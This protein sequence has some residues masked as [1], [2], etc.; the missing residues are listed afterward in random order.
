MISPLKIVGG[1]HAGDTA[2]GE[3]FAR[4]LIARLQALDW[5]L[6]H[7]QN[8]LKGNAEPGREESTTT[9][10][11]TPA[12]PTGIAAGIFGPST[13]AGISAQLFEPTAL[14]VKVAGV[15]VGGV[16]PWLQRWVVSDR[17]LTLTV[18]FQED[19]VIV[20]GNLDALGKRQVKPLY[21]EIKNP[22]PSSI[23]E[24]AAHALLQRRW[25]ITE[26]R[27]DRLNLEDFKNLV[28]SIT[29]VADTNDRVLKFKVSATS[30]Y[31]SVL[32]KLDALALKMATW[33]QLAYFTATVAE[34]AQNCERALYWYNHLKELKQPDKAPITDEM[35]TERIE[36]VKKACARIKPAIEQSALEKM[37]A[38]VA[39][40]T[41]VLNQIFGTSLSD[42]E[43]EFLPNDEL[44]AYWDGAKI[45][46]PPV[47]KDI[48][49]IVVHEAAWAFVQDAWKDFKYQGETGAIAQSYTDV[50]TTVVKQ[51]RL[52]QT[53][54][55][56][57][58][59]IAPG[60]INWLTRKARTAPT[61]DRE[62]LRSL[63]APGTAYDDP[64]V[65]KDPQVAHIRDLKNI[66][67]DNG[68]VHTNSGIPNKAFYETATRLSSTD[69]AIGIW[70]ATLRKLNPSI[71]FRGFATVLHKTAIELYG[72]DSQEAKHVQEAWRT[73]GIVIGEPAI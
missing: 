18:S 70:V 68:G 1:P 43:I 32:S 23:I 54:T 48:P 25:A 36:A 66:A 72:K 41:K 57:D 20:A 46:I 44:T 39:Y 3:T 24:E 8:S 38:D 61:E 14:D 59:E 5:D 26:P 29:Q 10:N 17:I 52:N 21:I 35:I 2:T 51:K 60:A 49:D 45:H 71:N 58:W 50:L 11:A 40:A 7:A 53:A 69:K 47:V 55:D 6:E 4:M 13:A 33:G 56:A 19:R 42:P 30:E 22:K 67:E 34:S 28:G 16:V 62:P 12:Q 73:V 9:A 37:K 65:G 64:V 27:L 15:D 31:A 63:K